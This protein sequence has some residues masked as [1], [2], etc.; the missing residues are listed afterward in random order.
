MMIK[1]IILNGKLGM[2]IRIMIRGKKC[3]SKLFAE[4]N[5]KLN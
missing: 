5:E 2:V 1:V 4:E 3:Q